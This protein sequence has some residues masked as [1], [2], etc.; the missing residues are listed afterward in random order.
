[1][2]VL[3]LA[4]T[5]H[6]VVATMRTGDGDAALWVWRPDLGRTATIEL[7]APPAGLRLDA[8]RAEALV[9][10]PGFAR[11]YA[12]EADGLAPAWD[13]PPL[14]FAPFGYLMPVLGGGI[15]AYERG[16][17]ELLRPERRTWALDGAELAAVSPDEGRV[18]WL[19]GR[20]AEG[21]RA[22]TLALEDGTAG[23]ELE[24]GELGAFVALAVGDDGTVTVATSFAPDG[25]R[26][27]RGLPDG[28]VTGVERNLGGAMRGQA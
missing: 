21:A 17:L 16:R 23:P 4:L 24:L 18:A 9:W 11:V 10:G 25:V 6:V 19:W 15:A 7:P 20:G 22:R 3:H 26:L 1:M 8:G 13:A 27:F 14:D 12:L 28:T 5:E 2:G